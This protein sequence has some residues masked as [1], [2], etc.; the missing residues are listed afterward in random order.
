[1]T[2]RDNLV[3]NDDKPTV[4]REFN[5][6]VDSLHTRVEPNHEPSRSS[7]RRILRELD[8]VYTRPSRYWVGRF[9]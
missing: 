3:V 1:M 8:M 6:R 7:E 5:S 4:A 2:R 9:C